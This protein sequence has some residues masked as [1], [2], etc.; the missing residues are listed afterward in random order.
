MP[1]NSDSE[2]DREDSTKIVYAIP[3]QSVQDE[4]DIIG[5]TRY[6]TGKWITIL[7]FVSIFTLFGV[8]LSK[9]MNREDGNIMSGQAVVQIGQYFVNGKIQYIAEPESLTHRFNHVH[10]VSMRLNKRR[11][12]KGL[13][14]VKVTGSED[15]AQKLAS[16]SLGAV[17]TYLGN[18]EQSI[19]GNGHSMYESSEII[20]P[21]SLT[22]VKRQ[23]NESAIVISFFILGLISAVVWLIV[24]KIRQDAATPGD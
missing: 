22:P 7:L 2:T 8:L 18:L 19:I 4:I 13:V 10:V 11:T 12:V 24:L 14:T 16:D 17:M 20:R 6:L 3:G 1:N 21:L 15:R 23:R 9:V 5:L